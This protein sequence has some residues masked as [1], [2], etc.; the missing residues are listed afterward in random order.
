MFGFFKEIYY[1]S[2]SDIRFMRHNLKSILLVSLMGP[3]LY[4]FAFGYALGMDPIDGVPYLA[5]IIP[6]IIALSSLM[7]AFSSTSAR[8][9]VQR[10]YY[11]SFDEMMMCPL[12]P[13]AIVLG[14]A[15]MG[16]LR[17]IITCSILFIIGILLA[18][19]YIF[20]T[21]E[22]VVVLLIS[23]LSF[24]L[25]GECAALLA[26]SHQSMATFSTLVILP[27]TF[28][29]GTFFEVSNLPSVFQGLLSF[30][31]LTHSSIC[32]RATVLDDAFPWFNF[33]VMIAFGV[34]FFLINMYLIKNKKV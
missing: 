21:P 1:V 19:E 27:M 30:L 2:W 24:A 17:S 12:R 32:I 15:V 18:P 14:K 26:K 25:L 10:L 23:S 8:M 16:V 6:G 3:L 29:C 9:N 33:L 5:F 4:I 34:A 31:P 11:R 13:S 7:S 20:F 22:F 28:L